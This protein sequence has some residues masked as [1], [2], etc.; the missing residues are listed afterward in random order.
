M[1]IK[2]MKMDFIIK[3]IRKYKEKNKYNSRCNSGYIC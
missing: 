2:E 3:L 1:S